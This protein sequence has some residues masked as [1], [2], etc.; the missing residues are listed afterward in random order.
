LERTTVLR[1]LWSS[2]LGIQNTRGR[3]TRESGATESIPQTERERGLAVE[4]EVG[5]GGDAPVPRTESDGAVVIETATAIELATRTEIEAGG[6]GGGGREREEPGDGAIV[7]GHMTRRRAKTKNPPTRSREDGSRS[8]GTWLR[9]DL[10]TSPLSS[11]K[12]CK[13]PVRFQQSE[14]LRL[15]WGKPRRHSPYPLLPN[16]LPVR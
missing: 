8:A 13:L 2:F 1:L 16:L 9:E 6:G 15:L 7:L 14:L 10:N 11:T 12:P 4:T 3:G 5:I